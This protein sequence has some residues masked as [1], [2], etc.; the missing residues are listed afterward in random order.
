LGEGA[1]TISAYA[2]AQ[3]SRVYGAIA[4]LRVFFVTDQDGRFPKALMR[5]LD[6]LPRLSG[7]FQSDGT[8]RGHIAVS[9]G[10]LSAPSGTVLLL[11]GSIAPSARS[12]YSAVWL[13]ADDR[14]VP[15]EFS[16]AAGGFVG[17]LPTSDLYSGLHHVTAYAIGAD[18]S[19][20]ARVGA[21]LAFQIVP[22]AGQSEFLSDPPP[23]CADPLKQLAVT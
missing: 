14:P 10:S 9:S 8:C 5:D 15:A 17:L 4:P 2:E 7:N 12:R 22:G 18:G 1:H 6:R 3:N 23:A 13:L 11:R 20:E 16:G 21:P 19:T